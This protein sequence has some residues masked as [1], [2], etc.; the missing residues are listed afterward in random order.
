MFLQYSTYDGSSYVFILKY[1]VF[2]L[3]IIPYILIQILHCIPPALGD[4]IME[5]AFFCWIG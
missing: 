4:K 2:V 1:N 5:M 3:C